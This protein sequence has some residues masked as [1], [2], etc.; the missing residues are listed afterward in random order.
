[1]Q[2]ERIEIDPIAIAEQAVMMALLDNRTDP[3]TRA[4]LQRL[5]AGRACDSNDVLDAIGHLHRAG[6]INVCGETVTATRAARRMDEL[7]L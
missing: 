7:E 3:W 5:I 1:M 4:E 6:L 2:A